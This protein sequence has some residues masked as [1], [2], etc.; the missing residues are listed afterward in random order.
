MW[1]WYISNNNDPIIDTDSH[2]V[3]ATGT[4]A[5]TDTYTPNGDRVDRDPAFTPDPDAPVD[6]NK[7]LRVVA[8]YTDSLGD[9][10]MARAVSAHMVRAEVSSDLDGV[11]NPANGSPGFSSP[12]RL[13]Q[14][15]V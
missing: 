11:A 12:E 15:R 4:G 13:H 10:R 8:T 6:E 1:Q 3:A 7:V 14:D 2:W 9:E 5:N